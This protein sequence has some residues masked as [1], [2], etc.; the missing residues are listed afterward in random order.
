[1]SR[2]SDEVLERQIADAL[3]T[4]AV[5]GAVASLAGLALVAFFLWSPAR[6]LFLSAWAGAMFVL[7]ALRVIGSLAYRRFDGLSPIAWIWAMTAMVSASG[8]IWGIG[9]FGMTRFCTDSELLVVF[10]V[11]LGA[12]MIT[13][14][15]VAFWPAM[16]GFQLCILGVSAAGL[17]T[18]G[19]PGHALLAFGAVLMIVICVVAG[20]RLS[21]KV[22]EAMR[23]AAAN[24][25]LVR[26]LSDQHAALHAANA[27]LAELSR[28]DGL[29]GL[30]NRRWFAEVLETEWMRAQRDDLPLSLVA[31]DI[32]QFKAYNDRYGHAAGDRCLKA[33]ALAM[34]ASARVGVDLAARPG[35][36]EFALILAG[37][38]A[39]EALAVA[40]RLRRAVAAVTG[41]PSA[42]LP[43]AAT[44]SLG[45]A[46]AWPGRG[47][48]PATLA[49]DAD[50]ALY[51]AKEHG[52]DRVETAPGSHRFVA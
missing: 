33:V 10:S 14:T 5:P 7:T 45:V 38:D 17:A 51:R 28:V 49:D 18:S 35:G 26:E 1:M 36:E 8:A 47:G 16:N 34:S 12:V 52:R 25:R 30:A 11:G 40:E 39:V 37:A 22:V 41:S 50:R 48:S 9:I 4:T 46:T 44:A 13:V 43:M 21:A 2:N 19:R 20:R 3:H 32:D 27:R 24:E 31:L 6:E 29:T 15:N 23:L 42:G